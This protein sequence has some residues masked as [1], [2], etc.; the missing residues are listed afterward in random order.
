MPAPYAVSFLSSGQTFTLVTLHVNYSKKAAERVPELQAIGKW[1]SGWVEREFD[2]GHNLI[3][4]G[5]STSIASATH[6]SRPS[7]PPD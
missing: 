5:G 6:C 1:L 2:W 3:A 7:P 4:L